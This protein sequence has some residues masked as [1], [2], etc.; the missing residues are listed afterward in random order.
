M[1]KDAVSTPVHPV[2]RASSKNH[3]DIAITVGR[4]GHQSGLVVQGSDFPDFPS[5][6]SAATISDCACSINSCDCRGHLSKPFSAAHHRLGDARELVRDCNG[7]DPRRSARQQRIDPRRKR[8]LVL[9]IADHGRGAENEQLAQVW[10]AL[11]GYPDKMHLAAGSELPR[12]QTDS[13]RE[14]TAGLEHTSVGGGGDD[15]GC[16]DHADIG[17]GLKPQTD[18]AGAVTLKG[19]LLDCL[20]AR[21]QILGLAHDQAGQPHTTEVR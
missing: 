2:G 13:G 4:R 3:F 15:S 16:R 14:V 1:Q 19:R 5:N 12:Y 17:D 10:F 9:R 8:R 21:L 11:L 7:H 18:F 20:A 6:S